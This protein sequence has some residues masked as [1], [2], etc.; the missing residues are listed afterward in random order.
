MFLLSGQKGRDAMKTDSKI[1]GGASTRR[2]RHPLLSSISLFLQ[3][4]QAAVDP[5]VR[6]RVRWTPQAASTAA[7]LM[8]LDS[9]ATLYGSFQQARACMKGDYRGCCRTGKTYNGLLKALERQ[10]HTVLPIVKTELRAQVRRRWG[11]LHST[12]PWVLLAV[13][14][15]KEDLPC[16]R[17]HERGFGVADN[18]FTP[19]AFITAIA[20][21]HTGLLW[22]WRLGRARASER[23]HLMEMIPD[24]PGDA[25]LLAD[26]GFVGLSVWEKLNTEGKHF[27][28]RVGSNVHLLTDLWPPAKTRVVRD[29]VYV[30]PQHARKTCP[31]LKLRLI[32]VGSGCKVM[33][34]LTNVL[35]PARLTRKAAG[36]IYRKRWGVELFYRTFKRTLGCAKLRSKAARRATIELEW[37]LV[38][39]T[40][41][42]LLGVDALVKRRHDPHRISHAQLLHTLRHALRAPPSSHRNTGRTLKRALGRCLKD[43]Y[44]RRKPK[45]SRHCIIT[46]NTP[47][48]HL[49]PPHVRPATTQEKNDAL[50]YAHL[51]A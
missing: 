27:L 32:K 43:A 12:H 4:L 20:E 48:T 22:D 47:S 17:D 3:C 11:H 37:A 2:Y 8:A 41:M 7:V 42:T 38:T 19:Q 1:G 36:A 28:I 13:D 5:A 39:M 51:A 44:T 29:I 46:K 18:G 26:A 50:K 15:S 23:Q 30:W 10:Q 49:R 6:R 34:L 40:L 45:H 24:L 21:V 25:L 35:E 14:G 16:T 31:P 33:H 9:D